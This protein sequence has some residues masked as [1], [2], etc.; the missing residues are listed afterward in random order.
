MSLLAGTTGS[1]SASSSP[2][3]AAHAHSNLNRK[4][5]L[6]R[7]PTGVFDPALDAEFVEQTQSPE[8]KDTEV[9]VEP[10]VLSVD[11]FLRTM[12]EEG[13]YHGN[14]PIGATIPALGYGTVVEAGPKASHKVG[15]RVAGMLAASDRV[16]V[17]SRAVVR[18]VNFPFL[19]PTA[20]LGL[21]GLTCG[22]TAYC[23]VF[24]VASRPP[25]KGETVVVTGAAGAVGSIATQLARSTGARVVG[26]AG[27]PRKG[28]YLKDTLGCDAV[29]DYKSRKESLHDQIAR[30]C[31]EGIDFVYDN[32]GGEILNALLY[33]INPRGRVVVCGAISQYSGKLHNGTKNEG[34]CGAD[35]PSNY[36]KLAERG[37]EMVGFN[38][39]QHIRKLPFMLVGMFWLW[40]RG[41]VVMHEHIEE[42]L[43]H[44]P[45]ALQK[46]FT[47]ENIGKT[48]VRV[49]PDDKAASRTEQTD[50]RRERK[51][52]PQELPR[53]SSKDIDCAYR[54]NLTMCNKT[55]KI[56]HSGIGHT[57][58]SDSLGPETCFESRNEQ[59]P[60]PPARNTSIHP[61]KSP[62]HTRWLFPAREIAGGRLDWMHPKRVP[63]AAASQSMKSRHSRSG[64][65]IRPGVLRPSRTLENGNRDARNDQTVSR[66]S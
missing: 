12:M 35:G 34:C 20:A 3:I 25:R 16:V 22:L 8:L 65:S 58:G 37:A 55:I 43:E 49:G 36:L 50:P 62:S 30:A 18:S 48:L 59:Q 13:A 4:W 10:Q 19:P 56:Y 54:K 7:R 27:G 40:A 21:L 45:H 60:A 57:F 33:R 41:K 29:I 51:A 64:T 47:G 38:V 46:L 28:A 2:M 17:D 31:P 53:K 44:F 39:M 32:V 42:G 52:C 9:L 1:I 15:T 26:V 14:L 61:S 5:T 66:T 6:K 24:Y 23:G 63:P 11:A